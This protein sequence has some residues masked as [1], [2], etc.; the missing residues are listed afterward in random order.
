MGK[1]PQ[2]TVLMIEQTGKPSRYVR[3]AGKSTLSYILPPL[4][5]FAHPPKP[6]IEYTDK[7]KNIQG[8]FGECP[9]KIKVSEDSCLAHNVNETP[10]QPQLGDR[11]QVMTNEMQIKLHQLEDQIQVVKKA[12]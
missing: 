12:L 7:W 5:S 4:P 11:P 1:V 6:T 3:L 8:T 10:I 9:N 2:N